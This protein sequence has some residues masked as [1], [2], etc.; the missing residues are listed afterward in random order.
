[1]DRYQS[2]TSDGSL[3]PAVGGV[4][5]ACCAFLLLMSEIISFSSDMGLSL[6]AYLLNGTPSP[7]PVDRFC[8]DVHETGQ[9]GNSRD[10][11]REEERR[12][13]KR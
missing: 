12:N 8:D 7:S 9:E 1:M 2:P 13:E 5:D 4:G 3:P 11:G 10:G 6:G